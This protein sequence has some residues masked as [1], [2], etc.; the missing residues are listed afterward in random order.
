MEVGHKRKKKGK[1][2]RNFQILTENVEM[3]QTKSNKYF[4]NISKTE[5]HRHLD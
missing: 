5:V 1:E 4:D 3:D 2:I